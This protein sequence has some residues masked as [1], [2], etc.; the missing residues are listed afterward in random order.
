MNDTHFL[1]G[2]VSIHYLQKKLGSNAKLSRE[3]RRRE[4]SA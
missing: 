4:A 3:R 1:T 2:G